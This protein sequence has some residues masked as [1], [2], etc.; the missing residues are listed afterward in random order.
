MNPAG[1]QPLIDAVAD[2][3]IEAFYAKAPGGFAD[4]QFSVVAAPD[5]VCVGV[6][7]G[8]SCVS[9]CGWTCG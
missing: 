4:R 9:E 5:Q 8:M 2:R 1:F 6:G 3:E 7:V